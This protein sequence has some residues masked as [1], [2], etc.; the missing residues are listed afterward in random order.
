MC[1]GVA[2]VAL[3]GRAQDIGRERNR[4]IIIMALPWGGWKSE[5][6]AFKLFLRRN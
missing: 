2:N 1:S 4:R 5:V 6:A 3:Y